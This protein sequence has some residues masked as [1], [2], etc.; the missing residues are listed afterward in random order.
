LCLFFRNY[1][2][3]NGRI[4]DVEKGV[5]EIAHK[6]TVNSVKELDKGAINF[7]K[8]IARRANGLPVR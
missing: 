1:F 8:N 5:A 3:I 7:A 2:F 4:V 6:E